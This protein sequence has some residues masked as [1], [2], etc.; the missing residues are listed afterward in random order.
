MSDEFSVGVG[1]RYI[2]SNLAAGFD[3]NNQ[4]KA[5][6]SVAGDL[7]FYYNRDRRMFGK[8]G[9]IAAGL[10][11]SNMGNKIAYSESGQTSF[12]PSN[13][14]LGTTITTIIDRYNKV[15]FSLDLNKLL[16]PTNPVFQRDSLNRIRLDANGSPIIER[17]SDPN[18]KS[19]I[20][21]MLG[22]FN[23]A[24]DGFKEELREINP[25]LGVE[26]LYNQVFALRG[27]Y[28]YEHPTKGGRQYF[29]AGMGLQYNVFNLNFSYLLP[30]GQLQTNPLANTLRFSL[31]FDLGALGKADEPEGSMPVTE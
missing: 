12:I 26:Y 7:S 14:R 31:M 16:V 27:G 23:D 24:P 19:V 6:N 10:V 30:V 3:P 11:V 29:T 4:F 1:L 17:G 8:E 25:S 2:Y 5:G 22:S 21:G 20:E 18:Q 13:L 28:M 9:N 15:S